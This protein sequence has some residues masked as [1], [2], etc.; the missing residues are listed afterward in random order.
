MNQNVFGDKC[1]SYVR[2]VEDLFNLSDP[3]NSLLS[4]IENLKQANSVF[5]LIHQINDSCTKE[6]RDANKKEMSDILTSY[7]EAKTP[8][9]LEAIYIKMD[10]FDVSIYEIKLPQE[11]WDSLRKA[12]ERID[13]L[14][15]IIQGKE[16]LIDS[17]EKEMLD[18]VKDPDRLPNKITDLLKVYKKQRSVKQRQ[19]LDYEFN[20]SLFNESVLENVSQQN[21]AKTQAK[22]TKYDVPAIT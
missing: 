20:C 15:E 5:G 11:H 13:S 7:N 2:A 19:E 12:S 6:K 17:L 16:F 1:T 22:S 10:D 8:E 3:E 4:Y 14:R 21:Y 18:I 9:E